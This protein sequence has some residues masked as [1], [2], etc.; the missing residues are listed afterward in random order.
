MHLHVAQTKENV[1]APVSMLEQVDLGS[2]Q[3]AGLMVLTL[4][5]PILK[6]NFPLDVMLTMVSALVIL[7]TIT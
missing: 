4:M 2:L 3:I 6:V 7:L 5:I 1:S